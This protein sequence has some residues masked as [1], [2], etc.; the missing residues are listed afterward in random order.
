MASSMY[1]L[2]RAHWDLKKNSTAH[3]GV[4]QVSILSGPS[5]CLSKMMTLPHSFTRSSAG[6]VSGHS[7]YIHLRGGG[8]GGGGG[9]E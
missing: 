3:A 2:M 8:G 5:V 1:L 6:S 9:G 4:L 7:A